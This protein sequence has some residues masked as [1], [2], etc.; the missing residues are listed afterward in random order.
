MLDDG[1]VATDKIMLE[2][3]TAGENSRSALFHPLAEVY[4][5]NLQQR[6][7]TSGR[8]QRIHRGID[9]PGA[10]QS[11]ASLPLSILWIGGSR[12]TVQMAVYDGLEHHRNNTRHMSVQWQ[13]VRRGDK[14]QR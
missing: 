7:E 12:W 2:A 13:P 11:A 4:R 10:E 8:A 6:R 14:N 3:A 9:A 1:M 5:R